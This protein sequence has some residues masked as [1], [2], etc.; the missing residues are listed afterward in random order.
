LAGVDEGT[1]RQHVTELLRWVGLGDHIHAKPA[2]LSGGQQQRIAIAR[3]VINRPAIL[4]ADEPTGNVDDD[5]GMR[6]MHLFLELNKLG[7]T[8]V[9]ASHNRNLINTLDKPHLHLAEGR[10][11]PNNPA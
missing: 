6:L 3:A 5:T 2:Q 9:I 11:N 4:L 10:L 8:V 1:I 7:T